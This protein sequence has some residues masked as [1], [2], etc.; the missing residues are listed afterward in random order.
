MGLAVETNF[1]TPE[2]AGNVLAK[3][4]LEAMTLAKLI[5]SKDPSVLPP[6]LLAAAQTTATTQTPT[7]VKTTTVETKEEEEEEEDSGMGSL[8]G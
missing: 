5:A 8:F 3:T 7:V 4:Q 2:T 1:I 6:E